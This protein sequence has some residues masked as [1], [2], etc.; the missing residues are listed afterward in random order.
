MIKVLESRAAVLQGE[1]RATA[2]D[3]PLRNWLGLLPFILLL[4]AVARERPNIF[5]APAQSSCVCVW[6]AFPP[7]P[8]LRILGLLSLSVVE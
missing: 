4:V 5:M 3:P 7:L 1:E 2:Q 6:E 8:P